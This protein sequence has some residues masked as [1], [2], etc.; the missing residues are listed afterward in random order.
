MLP[1]LPQQAS[2][3]APE[4]DSLLYLILWITGIAFVLVQALLVVFLVLYRGRPGRR[5][6]YTHGSATLEVIWTLVP[7]MIL[8]FLA[9]ISK[10][11]WDRI[12]VEMPLDAPV[13]VR[14]TGKQFNWEILYPGPD[15]RFDTADDLMLDNELH[16]PVDQE[17]LVL[18]HSKDVIHSFFVPDLRLKQDAV[19]GREIKAWFEATKTGV[20]E[21]P[22][23]E[24]CGFGHSGMKGLL[25][26][27][28][29]DD[30]ER[31]QAEKWPPPAGADPT[32]ADPG[33]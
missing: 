24:L 8:V 32:P 22:C 5:A 6:Y 10:A 29:P 21:I 7:S 1:W 3:Y 4:I 12:K 27:H 16:V 19:P 30:Y 9:F 31:W 28:A 15:R 23:A 33:A 2:T 18:L 26:V 20:F 17:V 11:S 25:T 13:Q 14:V